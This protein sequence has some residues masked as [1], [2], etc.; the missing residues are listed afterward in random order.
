MATIAYGDLSESRTREV[1]KSD[2]KNTLIS[3]PTSSLTYGSPV[4]INYR[5]ESDK[6]MSAATVSFEYSTDSEATWSTCTEDTSYSGTEGKTNL[7]ADA[8]GNDHVFAWNSLTDLGAAFSGDVV[9]RIRASDGTYWDDYITSDTISVIVSPI[10]TVSAPIGGTYGSPID[11]TYTISTLVSASTFSIEAEYSIDGSTWNTCTALTTD[12]NHDGISGLAAGTHTF[13]WDAE[14]ASDLGPSYQG[15]TVSV[16]VR[17]NNGTAWGNYASSST[18]SV[19]MF[20]I[21]II[22][23]PEASKSYGSP[24]NVTYAVSSRRESVSTFSITAK[25]RADTTTWYDCTEDTNDASDEGTTGLVVGTHTFVWNSGSDLTTAYQSSD[26]QVEVSASDGTNTSTPMQSATFTIDMLPVAPTLISPFDTYFDIGDGAQFLWYI[27]TDPGSDKIHF[28]FMIDE[29]DTGT[30]VIDDNTM[31]DYDRFRHKID[32]V[33]GL[34]NGGANIAYYVRN[35]TVTDQSGTAVLFS[36]LEDYF[37]ESDL[38]STL[39][40]PKIV[41]VN[42]ADREAYIPSSSITST[43]FTIYKR[44][45]GGS[46][47][48]K[49]DLIIFSG[50]ASSFETYWVTTTITGDTSF[51]YG[52]GDF[53]TDDLGNTIPSTITNCRPIILEGGDQPVYIS[54][55]SDTGFTVKKTTYG[56]G[57]DTPIMVM[58]MATPSDAYQHRE[59]TVSPS[60][61]QSDVRYAAALTDYTNGGAAWP[62]YI[63]GA[64]MGISMRAD[65]HAYASMIRGDGLYAHECGYGNA[66][67]ADVDFIC[68]GEPDSSVPYWNDVSPRGVPDDYEG[69]IARYEVSTTDDLADGWYKWSVKAGNA[70]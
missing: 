24:V 6:G 49:V 65:R 33:T 55:S 21:V 26:V 68:T 61:G 67:D 23:A 45:F 43:G 62:A 30:S 36:S 59:Y 34:K 28:E 1:Y 52:S 17:A 60:G 29:R 16:R 8:D 40:N 50:A 54:A 25:Y 47:D 9:L 58:L 20:P 69:K 63:P 42:K 15:N 56:P 14:N 11:I 12:A 4:V 22:T 35:M 66:V 51:T 31:D 13:V 46:G 27:P 32:A 3:A 53:A 48:A 18:F 37:K 2:V 7:S 38:P 57:T 64:N 10:V 44:T 41:L 70:T 5:L 19:D 39:T